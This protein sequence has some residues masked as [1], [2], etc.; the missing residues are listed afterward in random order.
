MKWN[1]TE[2]VRRQND[3]ETKDKKRKKTKKTKKKRW[4]F[5]ANANAKLV[6][7]RPESRFA[8]EGKALNASKAWKIERRKQ[9]KQRLIWNRIS[10][11]ILLSLVIYLLPIW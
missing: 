5:N 3:K 6:N 7:C 2:K 11:S 8:Y 9:M 4:G 1:T 10:V